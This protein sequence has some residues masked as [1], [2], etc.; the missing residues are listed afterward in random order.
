MKRIKK[1]VLVLSTFPTVEDAERICSEAVTKGFAA[2]INLVKTRSLFVW[3]DKME[4]ED[5]TMALMKTTR[6]AYRELTS[7]LKDNHPY[8]V[9]EILVLDLVDVN[10]RYLDWV[11][12]STGRCSEG[13]P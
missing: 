1:V 11:V 6:D 3:E 8:S 13:Q 2:C 10:K 12:A 7:F 9:P 4:K 5:E